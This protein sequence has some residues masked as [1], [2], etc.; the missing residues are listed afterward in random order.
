[1]A[2][3]GVSRR[4]LL[5]GIAAA[6]GASVVAASTSVA[7]GPAG[8]LLGGM[9]VAG[10]ADELTAA[11]TAQLTGQVVFPG[12][13]TYD[14]ARALWDGVFVTYPLVIVFCQNAT[15]VLNALAWSRQNGVALRP[16][17]WTTQPGGVVIG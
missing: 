6:G 5:K 10:A 2:D 4:Q 15:D 17:K 3:Y 13:P 14:T 9:S 12:D 7:G 8:A 11:P 1:M 16:A